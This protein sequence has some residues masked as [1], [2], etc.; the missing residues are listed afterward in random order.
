M[1]D[2]ISAHSSLLHF[3]CTTSPLALRVF[4]LRLVYESSE[5]SYL[6]TSI[7][8]KI[9]SFSIQSHRDRPVFTPPTGSYTNVLTGETRSYPK[10]YSYR[11]LTLPRHRCGKVLWKDR[12][13][14]AILCCSLADV[15]ARESKLCIAFVGCRT[16]WHRAS[17]CC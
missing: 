13:S 5:Q 9:N 10:A 1:R 14:K 3:R 2:G 11:K 7:L 15:R 17:S 4:Q 8:V 12:R 6:F 16:R